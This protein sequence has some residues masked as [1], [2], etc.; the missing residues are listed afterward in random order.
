ML[1]GI[2]F[3]AVFF[4]LRRGKIP[5]A[6]ILS[7]LC[8]GWC[9]QLVQVGLTGIF[10]FLAGAG[11][12]LVLLAVLFYF[13]MLGAGDIKL[14]AVI[15]GF[16]GAEKLLSCMVY[17]FLLGGAISVLLIIRR[18]NLLRRL[19]YFFA[20]ISNYF[21]TK[22]WVS[23]RKEEEKDGYFCFSIPVFLS[24]LLYVGGYY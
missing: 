24:V 13:R 1:L 14:F 17:S 6:L 3:L 21:Q 9:W 2:I 19:H 15:G 4:D 11:L 18:R 8:L 23:Y 20:Y 22:T 10:V 12:P 16:M 5:N 7:G